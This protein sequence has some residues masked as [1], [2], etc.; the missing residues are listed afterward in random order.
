MDIWS[1]WKNRETEWVDNK[2]EKNKEYEEEYKRGR[3]VEGGGG[4]RERE[5]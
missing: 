1:N 5:R 3:W 4:Q 2:E